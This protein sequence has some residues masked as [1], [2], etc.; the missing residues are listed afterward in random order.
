M[1]GQRRPNQRSNTKGKCHR[2][3][4]ND[5]GNFI[6]SQ[7]KTA[8]VTITD[9]TGRDKIEPNGVAN[10]ISGKR[11]EGDMAVIKFFAELAERN[12]IINSEY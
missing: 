10:G 3:H 11:G 4:P 5:V 2:H 8:I 12:K 6:M 1:A 7:I 9:T